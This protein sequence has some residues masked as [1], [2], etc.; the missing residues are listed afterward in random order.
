MTDTQIVHKLSLLIFDYRFKFNNSAFYNKMRNIILASFCLLSIIAFTNQA[1]VHP[2]L[3]G[4]PFQLILMPNR[5]YL[6]EAII[7]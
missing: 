2:Y 7:N 1:G 5:I 3:L 6:F 4:Y